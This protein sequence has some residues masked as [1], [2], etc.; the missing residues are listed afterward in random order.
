M[1]GRRVQ[2]GDSDLMNRSILLSPLT[3]PLSERLP[4]PEFEAGFQPRSI[5]LH[6]TRSRCES[7][8]QYS[9]FEPSVTSSSLGKYFTETHD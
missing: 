9:V 3:H 6:A 1:K 8:P 5:S 4:P 7:N 2:G